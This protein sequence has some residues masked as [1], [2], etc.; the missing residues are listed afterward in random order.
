MFGLLMFPPVFARN[1]VGKV[2]GATG[3]FQ[4]VQ[5]LITAD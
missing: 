5:P 1:P 2:Q 4:I 3:R